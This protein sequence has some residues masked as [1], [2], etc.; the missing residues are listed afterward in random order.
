M[1]V[2]LVRFAAEYLIFF[3]FL[4][5]FYFFLKKDY[6]LLIKI[7][8]SMVLAYLTRI[9]VGQFWFEPRPFMNNPQLL[10]F[11]TTNLDSS[12]FS[13]HAAI[14]FALAGSVYLRYKKEGKLFLVLAAIIGTGRVL[15]GLH[16]F[17]DVITGALIGLLYAWLVN[18]YFSQAL[19]KIRLLQQSND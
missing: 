19:R 16:Y 3:L 4:S 5:L 6:R 9:V 12:F 2:F 18:K 1:Y 11:P 10:L 14:S 8:I 17:G 15:A 7:L 13:S